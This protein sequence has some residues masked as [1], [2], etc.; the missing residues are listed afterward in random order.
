M[1]LEAGYRVHRNLNNSSVVIEIMGI[2]SIVKNGHDFHFLHFISGL[3]VNNGFDG[4]RPD[5]LLMVGSSTASPLCHA[6]ALPPK[7]INN[8]NNTLEGQKGQTRRA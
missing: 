5:W 6:V 1:T 3:S 7:T 4:R 8:S 2:T